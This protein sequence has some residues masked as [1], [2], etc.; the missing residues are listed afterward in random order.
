M[1]KDTVELTKI[2]QKHFGK[3]PT[4]AF[5]QIEAFFNSLFDYEERLSSYYIR[6]NITIIRKAELRLWQLAHEINGNTDYKMIKK[7]EILLSWVVQ[8]NP[9]MRQFIDCSKSLLD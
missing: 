5:S 2:W 7:Y 8:A 6:H 1:N 9:Y 3:T 4:I